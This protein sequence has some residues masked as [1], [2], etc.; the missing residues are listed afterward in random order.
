MNHLD[1]SKRKTEWT[2]AEDLVLLESVQLRGKKWSL[3]VRQLGHT[4]TEHMV[5]N[6][7]KSLLAN[8]AKKHPEKQEAELEVLLIKRL[9]KAQ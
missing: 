5:K 4:R 6:R 3:A 9:S 2:T 8:E 7:Y 1:P